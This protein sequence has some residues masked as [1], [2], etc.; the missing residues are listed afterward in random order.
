VMRDKKNYPKLRNTISCVSDVAL[1]SV[2]CTLA[3]TNC[4]DRICQAASKVYEKVVASRFASISET[5][6]I[7]PE[8]FYPTGG[9]TL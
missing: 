8:V 7:K 1:P 5:G 2:L 4:G 6:E 3:H 9:G